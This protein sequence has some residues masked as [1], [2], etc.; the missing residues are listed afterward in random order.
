MHVAINQA[1]HQRHAACVQHRGAFWGNQVGTHGGN[2][3]VLHQNGQAGAQCQG[4]HIQNAAV[5][6]QQSG[7]ELGQRGEQGTSK[8]LMT[9][10]PQAMRAKFAGFVS[11]MVQRNIPQR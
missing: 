1:G 4:M 5:F 6:N 11:K 10:P 3:A 2:A 8:I 9:Y 7:H